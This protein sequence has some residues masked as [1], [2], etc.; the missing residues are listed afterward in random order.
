M[1]LAPASSN[2]RSLCDSLNG[3]SPLKACPQSD[4]HRARIVPDRVRE[5]AV[6]RVAI[7]RQQRPQHSTIVAEDKGIAGMAPAPGW[8]SRHARSLYDSAAL[9]GVTRFHVHKT[10]HTFACDWLARGGSLT[11]L[12]QLLGHS[13]V[14]TTQRYASLFTEHLVAEARRIASAEGH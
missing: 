6:E 3:P 5:A 9:T 11:A 7:V 4:A 2:R 14:T 1:I 10:R 12:Q 13:S 8:R